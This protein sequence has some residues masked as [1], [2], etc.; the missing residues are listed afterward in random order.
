MTIKVGN[1]VV[2]NPFFLAPLAG[3]TDKSFRKLCSEKGA[4]L[5]YSEMVS[6][7][8]MW[9]KDKKT[10]K[11]LEIDDDESPIGFQLFGSEPEILAHAVSLLEKSKNVLIDVN[12]GCPVPKIV[13][14]GEGSALLKNPELACKIIEAM[15]SVATKPITAKI[16]I[17][18]DNNSINAVSFAKMLEGAGADAIGIHGRTREQYYSGKADWNIIGEVKNAV[19]VPVFGNGDVKCG[20]DAIDLMKQTGCDAVM[21]ARGSMGN[22]WIFEEANCLFDGREFMPPTLNEKAEMFIR[23]SELV[24]ADKGEHTAVL[25]MRKHVGWYFKGE[26]QVNRLKDEINKI[27]DLDGVKAEIK[28]YASLSV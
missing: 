11:L 23:H 21:I 27:G 9:Y 16:R 7:K 28:K 14:N 6:A 24:C 8:A 26:W 19:T 1:I 22:P 3:I 4:A 13:K 2:N 5:V 20:Q 15:K 25:E 17:G 10:D 12:M 18:W